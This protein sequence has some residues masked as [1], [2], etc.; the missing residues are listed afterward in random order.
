MSTTFN[1]WKMKLIVSKFESSNVFKDHFFRLPKT[2]RFMP[3]LPCNRVCFHGAY[4]RYDMRTCNFLL[5]LYRCVD[6][7]L[8]VLRIHLCLKL[9]GWEKWPIRR[10]TC[11]CFFYFL[12]IVLVLRTNEVFCL[13]ACTLDG[14]VG[15]KLDL[16]GVGIRSDGVRKFPS[17]ESSVWFVVSCPSSYLHIVV[18]T[19]LLW[20]KRQ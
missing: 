7:L 11:C 6:S 14:I 19:F 8:F 2:Q 12:K 10:I 18:L 4:I 16:K 17:T 15:V 9:K 13:E 5:Y 20:H 3:N 1:I